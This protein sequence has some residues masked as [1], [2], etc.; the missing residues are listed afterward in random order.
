MRRLGG[1]AFAV[2]VLAAVPASGAT[3]VLLPGCG[4]TDRAAYKPNEVIVTCGDGGFR[5]VKLQWK[6][7]TKRTAGA[8]GTAKVNNCDPTCAGGRFVSYPVKLTLG[9]PRTCTKYAKREFSRLTYSFPGRHPSG[10]KRS[11]TLKR[12]CSR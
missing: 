12:P 5:V 9:K 7:W 1:I 4:G 6:T 11:G 8:S 2:A 10:A 3:K